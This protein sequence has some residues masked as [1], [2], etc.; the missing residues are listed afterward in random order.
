MKSPGDTLQDS[1]HCNESPSYFCD[2]ILI[3]CK[4]HSFSVQLLTHVLKIKSI[5][6]KSDCLIF[7]NFTPSYAMITEQLDLMPP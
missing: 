2:K 7:D 6:F 4:L 3:D 1:V 5:T